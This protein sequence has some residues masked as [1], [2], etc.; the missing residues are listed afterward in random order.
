MTAADAVISY[1]DRCHKDYQLA[2]GIDRN[3]AI[4]YGFYE[5]G[6]RG[7]DE[8]RRNSN[9]VLA[10]ELGVGQGDFV[11]DAGCG[12][13]GTCIWLAEQVGARV[14]GVNIQPMH[15][16][17]ARRNVEARGLAGHVAFAQRD[18]CELP[19]PD[20]SA[21][22]LFSLE[23]I[24]HAPDKVR[25]LREAARVLKPGGRLVIFDYFSRPG[26]L[27]PRETRDRAR[28]MQGWA[29]PDLPP[30]EHY[31]T[32]L[33]DLGFCDIAYR[34]VTRNVLPD[35]RRM[36]T[37]CGLALPRTYWRFWRGRRPPEVLANRVSGWLQHRL[38]SR[39]VLGYGVL[40]AVR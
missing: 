25:F 9:R 18:Y 32:A 15:L 7:Q 20:G 11:I 2:W 37:L 22:G 27:T 12:V 14:L 35:S 24:A 10:H 19:T 39:G 30:A 3:H 29:L 28:F 33:S 31:Q 16:D 21:D 38:F 23:G 17:I 40:T 34:D 8:A 5:P 6:V 13:G 1:Y 4:H 36:R 26:P